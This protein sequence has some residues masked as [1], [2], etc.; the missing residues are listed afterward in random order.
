MPKAGPRK[1]NRTQ[2]TRSRRHA[3][4]CD[5]RGETHTENP[6]QNVYQ[7]GV[8]SGIMRDG[9]KTLLNRLA[10]GAL[11]SKLQRQGPGGM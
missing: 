1:V 5:R 11:G 4:A 10:P 3:T 7:G 6:K 2:A 9:D 8:A